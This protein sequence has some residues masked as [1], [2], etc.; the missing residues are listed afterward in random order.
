AP[1]SVGGGGVSVQEGSTYTGP[2]GSISDSNPYSAADNFSVTYT[3]N[4][5]TYPVTLSGSGGSYVVNAANIGPFDLGENGAGGTVFAT[6][7]GITFTGNASLSISDAPLSMTGN[8]G[9][10]A[11]VGQTLNATVATVTDQDTYETGAHLSASVAWNDG[12]TDTGS[13]RSLGSGV[14]DVV[15]S[16]TFNSAGAI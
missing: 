14:F 4:G 10:S 2:V 1:F 3:L 15:V 13:L 9:L 8:P 5:T 7:S 16:H 12:L 6:E 11:I